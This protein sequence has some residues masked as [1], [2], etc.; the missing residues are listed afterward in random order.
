MAP[1]VTEDT[2]WR[3]L[4]RAVPRDESATN[5]A[6]PEDHNARGGVRLHID[7]GGAWR[8][9][10]PPSDAARDLLDLYLPLQLDSGL[11]IGQ[12][13]QSLDGLSLIHI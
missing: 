9:S 11:V 8:T 2:A 5:R 3:L 10:A 12:I 6:V 4:L 7:P 13:G 1:L